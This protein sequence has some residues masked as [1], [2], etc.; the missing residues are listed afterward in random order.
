MIGVTPHQISDFE[1][2]LNQIVIRRILE[3]LFFTGIFFLY[4]LIG[5]LLRKMTDISAAMLP[6]SGMILGEFDNY[7]RVDTI[8]I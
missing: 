3:A 5:T 6:N 1:I 7:I 8:F 4:N 2:A